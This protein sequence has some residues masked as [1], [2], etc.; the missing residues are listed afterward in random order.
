MTLA[1]H[2]TPAPGWHGYWSNPGDAGDGMT[3]DW[4]LPAGWKAGE[5]QY[6][7]PRELS[8]AG[9]MNHVYEAE[10]AVLVP[11]AVPAGAN[12]ADSDRARSATRFLAFY[13]GFSRSAPLR[14]GLSPVSA[15]PWSVIKC[16]LTR[17]QVTTLAWVYSL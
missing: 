8:I 6:P 14:R 13:H 15:S 12:G 11:V 1:I 3:L 4:H 16:E 7:V 2:F 9:L 5:P 10:Y 17:D